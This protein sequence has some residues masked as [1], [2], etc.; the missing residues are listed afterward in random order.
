MAKEKKSVTRKLIRAGGWGLARR[1]GRI[2]PG[3]GTIIA[4]SFVGYDIKKKGFVKGIVNSGLDAVPFVGAGKNVIEMITGDL[5]P[6]KE[7]SNGKKMPKKGKDEV[8]K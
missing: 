3:V 2:I 4:V 7:L 5:I 1:V 6:D 8:K